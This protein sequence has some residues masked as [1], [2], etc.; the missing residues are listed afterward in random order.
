MKVLAALRRA[1]LLWP[2]VAHGDPGRVAGHHRYGSDLVIG[3]QCVSPLLFVLGG[4]AI[5]F[6][7]VN[8][9]YA[10]STT[11]KHIGKAIGV[12]LVIVQIPGSSG[13]YPSR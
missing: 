10:L 9:I 13:M 8:I 7:Y 2:L 6:T 3:V 1:K 4:I 11:F 12:I 5:S